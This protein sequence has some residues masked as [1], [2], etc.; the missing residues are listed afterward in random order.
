MT[1][2]WITI[3]ALCAGTVAV[4]A[5]GPLAVGGREPSKRASAVIRLL[6]PALL[7]AL[8]VYESL[9]GGGRGLSLDARVVGLVAAAIALALRRSLIVV[10]VVAA[11]ATAVARAL[12]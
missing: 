10:V 7:A 12:A 2:V 9:N 11:A 6:A 4:K 5:A 8:V 3:A 1:G